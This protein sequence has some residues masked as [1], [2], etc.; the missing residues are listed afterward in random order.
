M[1]RLWPDGTFDAGGQQTLGFEEAAVGLGS[2][3]D[4]R[5]LALQGDGKIVV[6]GEVL[7]PG[8][9]ESDMALARFL[10]DGLPDTSFGDQGHVQY[11]FGQEDV[12][13][14]VALQSDGKIVVAGYTDPFGSVARNFMIA[15]FNPD[16]T[17][18]G[19]FGFGGFNVL[20]FM[21]GEDYGNA[22]ALAPDGKIVVAGTVF[23]G[24]RNVFGIARFNADGTP[25]T[26]FDTDGKQLVE[27]VI[28]LSHVANA[29]V[30][31]PDRKIV[32]AGTVGGD[33][34]LLRLNENGSLDGT[35]GLSGL[36][37]T[38]MGGDDSL[39][40][41]IRLPNG[42][43]VA[44][45]FRTA[46]GNSDFALAQYTS[47]GNLV[48]CPPFPCGTWPAGKTFVDWGPADA[49]YALDWRSD[50]YL[51]VAGCAGG[52]FAWAQLRTNTLVGGP[53]KATTDFVGSGECASGVKFVGA[54]KIVVAGNQAFNGD[55]NFALARFETIANVNVSVFKVFLPDVLR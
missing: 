36:M 29:V 53:L 44:A 15:R 37:R 8:A 18:D 10:P 6:A 4:A 25:D 31:Q 21:G 13:R 14:G 16:G 47:N 28:G 7:I 20:D 11:G 41:L 2:N 39:N 48:G 5:G 32:V 30:V 3:E 19:T 27:F 45:G 1:I 33:F 26:S 35:F 12:A 42:G 22:L 17:E 24:A 52:N 54:N 51:V 38:D 23:N 40:A 9:A 46:S 55:E 49:A 43:F 34:A 50:G